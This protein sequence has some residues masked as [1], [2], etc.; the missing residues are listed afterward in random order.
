M[1]KFNVIFKFVVSPLFKQLHGKVQYLPLEANDKRLFREVETKINLNGLPKTQDVLQLLDDSQ[2][3]TV[4]GEECGDLFESF[5]DVRNAFTFEAVRHRGWIERTPERNIGQSH[6]FWV[7]LILDQGDKRIEDAVALTG[8][9]LSQLVR[10]GVMDKIRPE[11][12][13]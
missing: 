9:V 5:Q 4:F 13:R 10:F 3:E 1:K 8:Y 7:E 2:L 11:T 6:V 12:K